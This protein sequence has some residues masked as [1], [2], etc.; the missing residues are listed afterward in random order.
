MNDRKMAARGRLRVY[1]AAAVSAAVCGML[2]VYSDEASRAVKKGITM[3]C[4]G[5]IPSLFPMMFL[6]QYMIRSGA[7]EL[8]GAALEKPARFLLGLPGVCGVALMTAFVGGYPAGA[9]A[10]ETLVK[11]GRITRREGMRLAETA[12]CSGPGFAIGM[13][14]CGLYKNKTVGLLI[15]TAQAFSCIIIGIAYRLFS[16]VDSSPRDSGFG[17]EPDAK[18]HSDAFVRS[19]TG[20]ASVM[21]D[22]CA[23][24]VLFQVITALLERSGINSALEWAVRS[25]GLGDVGKILLPCA[26]EVTGGSVLSVKMGLPFTAFVVGFGGLSVHFQIFALCPSI[27]PDKAR[28]LLVRIAQGA[29]CSLLVRLGLELPYFSGVSLPVWSGAQSDLPMEFSGVSVGFGCAM[30]VMCLMSVICLPAEKERIEP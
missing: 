26:A 5:V 14:G 17:N 9:K 11:E 24:I 8:A 7:A 27:R 21:L 30:L 1:F 15:L 2:I 25:A 10:A 16:A 29:I 12:F 28:Y 6:S 4:A 3:C 20:T 19:A 23:F 18:S 22:M 13:V